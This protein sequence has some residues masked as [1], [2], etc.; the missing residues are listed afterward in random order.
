MYEHYYL[1]EKAD[2][3]NN[4]EVHTKDCKYLPAIENRIYLGYFSSCKDAVK[5]AKEKKVLWKIDGCFFC[6]RPCHRI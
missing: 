4:H 2:F 5:V 3:N 1:N 6:S